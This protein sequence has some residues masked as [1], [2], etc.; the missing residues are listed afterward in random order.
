MTDPMTIL[1]AVGATLGIIDTVADQVE[2]FWKKEPEPAAPK[3]HAVIAKRTDDR[4]DFVSGDA[5]LET[6]TADDMKQLDPQSQQLIETLEKSM[7]QQFDLWTQ[8][9]PQRDTSPDPLVNAKIN[10]Q[11]KAI[12][13]EM[14][15]DLN[16]ILSFLESM[17]KNLHDHYAHI[18]FICDGVKASN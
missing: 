4:I 1:A 12:A 13:K 16:K 9:Y 14:C 6:I 17:G 10:A 5:V 15:S 8:I 2:R 18:Q 3:L 7:R 11:L